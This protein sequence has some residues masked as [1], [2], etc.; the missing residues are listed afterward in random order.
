MKPSSENY[1]IW[2]DPDPEKTGEDYIAFLKILGTSAWLTFKG[3]DSS[4][5]RAIV[6]LLHGN[7]PSGLK[8][9]HNW[10]KKNV[11]PETDLG[12]FVGSVEAALHLPIL[13]HRYLPHEKDFNRCFNPP[14]ECN[15]GRLA[16]RLINLLADYSPEAVI[17]TH[18][19]SA[20]SDAFAVAGHDTPSIRQ[21]TQMFTRKLVV[22]HRRM[23]TLI[24]S[25]K[26]FFPVLTVEFG[27]FTD[28][29]AD[30][31]AEETLDDFIHRKD[32]FNVEAGPMQILR[33]P[34]RLEVLPGHRLHYSSSI[35]DEELKDADITIFNTIDQL[36]FTLVR[37][38]TRLGWLAKDGINGLKVTDEAGHNLLNRFFYERDGF[39]M[40]AVDMNIFMAT[41]DPYIAEKDCLLYLTAAE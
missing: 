17:D 38:H 5:R 18:N 4:R 10:I 40:T 8:A 12:I 7:E 37:R 26:D 16:S 1:K 35:H 13:S 30:T 2:N 36:N 9:V 19:T 32:L 22:M 25:G 23:G 14:F 3:K 24:E 34:H 28:P 15:Q 20:H 11:I 33:D 6:T 27:G 39:L 31:L 21:L 41:T 29:N